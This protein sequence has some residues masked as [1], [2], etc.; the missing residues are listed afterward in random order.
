MSGGVGQCRGM[1]TP[2]TP[3]QSRTSVLHAGKTAITQLVISGPIN[4]PVLAAFLP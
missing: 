3:A 2:A 4:Q 1:D